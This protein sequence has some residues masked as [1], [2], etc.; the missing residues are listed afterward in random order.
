MALALAACGSTPDDARTPEPAKVPRDSLPDGLY[1]DF[2]D[3]KYDGAGHP[4]GAQVWQAESGCN[5]EVGTAHGEELALAGSPGIACGATPQPIG[6]GRFTLN[7]RALVES[8]CDSG[9]DP[10]APVLELAVLDETGAELEVQAVPRRAFVAPLTYQNVSLAFSHASSGAPR[11][12]VRYAGTEPA[13]IDYVELF[14]SNRNLLVTPPS[15]LADPSAHFQVEV[16]DPPEGFALGATCDAVDLTAVLDAMLASGEATRTDTEFRAIYDIPAAK[17]TAGCALPARVR[18]QVKTDAW[19]RA[20]SRITLFGEQAPCTFVPGTKRVLLTGF[21]PFPA[22]STRDN[23]SE[24]AVSAFDESALSG[25]SV[26]RLTLPV[27]FDTAPDL[28]VDAIDRCQPHVVVG[29]G[30]GRTAVDLETT[31]YN[32]KD[33]SE[34]SGGVPDNRGVIPGSEP[35]VAGGP[36][37]RSSALP[38]E[39]IQSAI[40]ARGIAVGP[41]DDPGRYVC[42]NVFYRITT[43]TAGTPTL[44]GFVHLPRIPNVGDAER[45]MLKAVVTEVVSASVAAH[46][47]N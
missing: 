21:E 8:P 41:S 14:R 9:C 32:L 43:A 1:A 29:F 13:R 39:A 40:A 47:S 2:L 27:E 37:E 12:E 15:G 34:I 25:I 6:L 45:E 22:D 35:I 5:A 33:S 31:A 36:A 23:S 10:E 19:V 24:Q 30:Q 16:Q 28:V 20:T 7:V 11:F 42:N 44:A 18:F 4:L 38:L 26:M 17:L 3:G 46:D